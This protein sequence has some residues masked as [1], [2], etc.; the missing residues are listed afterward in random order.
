MDRRII[1][2]GVLLL[3]VLAAGCAPGN[4]RW[5]SVDNRANFW[6]GLWHGLIVIVTFIVSLFTREVRIYEGN[7]VGWAYNL[8]FLLGCMISLG[9]GA[10]ASAR[11]KARRVEMDWDKFGRQVAVSIREGLQSRTTAGEDIAAGSE[12]TRWQELGRRIEERV[13]EE[14]RKHGWK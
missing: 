3:V 7:N 2:V 10:R 14:L 6:A 8:G 12:E 5:A 13:R 1:L 4:E 9:S 11:R